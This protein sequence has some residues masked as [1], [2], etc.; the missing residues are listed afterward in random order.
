MNH[1]YRLIWSE[2]L[3]AF[4]AV[5]EIARGRGKRSGGAKRIAPVA[6]A[7]GMLAGGPAFALGTGEQVAAGTVNFARPDNRTLVVTQGSDQAIVNWQSFSIGAGETTRFVQPSSSAVILNRILGNDASHIYGNLQANGIVFLTNPNGILF[8]RGAQV[9]VGGLVAASLGISDQNFLNRSYHFTNDG[10]AGSIVNGANI[11]AATGYVALIAPQVSNTG[12]IAASNGS[13]GLVAG[14]AVVL[15]FDHD[16]KIN[17]KIDLPAASARI[18]NSGLIAADGGRVVM[19]ASAKDALLSTVLNNSGIVRA[20]GLAMKNGEI[21]LDG[22]ASGVT[23]VTGTL[24]ASGKEAGQTGGTVKVLGDKVGLFG[25]ARIDVAGDAG[26]GTALVGG[27]YQ[28]KGA[29]RNANATYVGNAVTINADALTAGNG[30]K[31]AIWSDNVTRYYGT[32]SA[33][34]GFTGGDGGFAEIS[35][36]SALIFRGTVKLGATNGSLGTL[37]LDPLTITIADGANSSGANDDQLTDPAADTA[38]NFADTAASDFTISAGQI[39]A[40]TADILLEARNSIILGDLADGALTLQ[41]NVTLTARTR[42][43]SGSGDAATGGISFTD[44][45]DAIVASGTGGIVLQAGTSN[46]LSFN[47]TATS[48]I[49]VGKL[50]TNGGAISL[51]ASRNVTLNNDVNS[52]NGTL[53]VVANNG[54]FTQSAGTITADSFGIRTSGAVVLT[55][56]NNVTTLAAN[57]SGSGNS[58]TFQNETDGF[59][60]G[61]VAAA[62]TIYA[63]TTGI[64]TAD[65]TAGSSGGITLSG[66]GAI[67]IN[68]ALA[69]GTS[70]IAEAGG[71]ETAQTG[72]IQ[73][74]SSASTITGNGSGTLTTGAATVDGTTDNDSATSGT[75]TLSASGAIQLAAA[76]AL[77][78]GTT[79]VTNGNA[80][81]SALAGNITVTTADKMTADGTTGKVDVPPACSTSPP[82]AVPATP[83]ASS[84]PRARR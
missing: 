42:N 31:V 33:Q 7:L 65:V 24:D 64:T 39:E 22:G 17:F 4:V 27:N 25:Q 81:D 82:T 59:A 37:L 72:A 68:A 2:A 13:V 73:I 23:S 76:D 61:T 57:V 70:N 26:G 63:S 35:G 10:G 56:A 80:G 11:N 40:L 74:T 45:N 32:L 50:T 15:D 14:D 29:E 54:T 44:T 83:A 12:A 53:R 55:A 48:D 9:D 49:S 47:G 18:D 84:S 30:G 1:A 46:G 43:D 36:R 66:S 67:A 78:V 20:R 28:G 34:G 69:T 6:V 5:A 38:I 3:N 71:A 62:G 16:G 75:I 19:N 21:V 41:S 51:E 52:G 8:S 79:T 77:N 60:V 58:F